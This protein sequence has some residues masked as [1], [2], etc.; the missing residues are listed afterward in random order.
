MILVS[1][2]MKRAM[3]LGCLPLKTRKR[4]IDK[5]LYDMSGSSSSESSGSEDV[6]ERRAEATKLEV[7]LYFYY[8]NVDERN[9]SPI[10]QKACPC[11]PRPFSFKPSNRQLL[12]T[13][14]KSEQRK[15]FG[16]LPVDA[17]DTRKWWRKLAS[18]TLGTILF[19]LL[20]N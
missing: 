9:T 2:S 4:R 10:P 20:S 15:H 17:Y 14:C 7:R 11:A 18:T 8:S 3:N 16:P 12:L 6:N 13:Q 19:H 5:V 1:R